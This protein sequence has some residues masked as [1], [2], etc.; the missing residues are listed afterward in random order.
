MSANDSD[1]RLLIRY[2]VA[3]G[4]LLTETGQK[5]LQHMMTDW[6]PRAVYSDLTADTVRVDAMVRPG[7]MTGKNVY[8]TTFVRPD[9][10]IAK[11]VEYDEDRLSGCVCDSFDQLRSGYCGQKEGYHYRVACYAAAPAFGRR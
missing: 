5:H 3:D 8:T 6:F 10:S 1:R 7:R 2:R 4:Y 9:G 11:T